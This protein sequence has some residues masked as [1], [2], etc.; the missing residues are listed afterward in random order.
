MR[1][2]FVELAAE[3]SDRRCYCHPL[4]LALLSQFSSATLP[5]LN[6]DSLVQTPHFTPTRLFLNILRRALWCWGAPPGRPDHRASPWLYGMGRRGRR[7]C[8]SPTRA[9]PTA[10]VMSKDVSWAG[11]VPWARPVRPSPISCAASRRRRRRP[12]HV[13]ASRAVCR[14]KGWPRPDPFPRRRP[15]TCYF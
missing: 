7:P 6:G 5:P 15:A 11:A 2:L 13:L 12:G 1:R 10:S 9:K 8:A 3:D 4:P 14:R